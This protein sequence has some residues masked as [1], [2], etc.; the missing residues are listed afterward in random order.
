MKHLKQNVWFM[1]DGFKRY[2]DGK[3]A[4]IAYC[5]CSGVTVDAPGTGN[6]QLSFG[7]FQ[8]W[9]TS[10]FR[11]SALKV[12]NPAPGIKRRRDLEGY[13][14]PGGAAEQYWQCNSIGWDN[15]Y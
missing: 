8:A 6:T 13:W 14:A 9:A 10:G 5:G 7:R 1:K 12:T 11:D 4:A 15:C 3:E 2:L